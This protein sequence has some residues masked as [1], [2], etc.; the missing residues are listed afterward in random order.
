MSA[1]KIADKT[2]AP[3][4]PNL[5]HPNGLKRETFRTSRL[6]DFCS[7]RELVKQIGHAVNYWPLVILKELVDNA[8]D[9]AEEAN[10]APTIRI[11]VANGE[12]L[13]TDNGRRIHAETVADILDFTV[14]VSS[15]K[16]YA[17]PTWAAQGNALKTILAMGSALDSRQGETLIESHG[18]AHGI[19][20]KV[21]Q[22]RQEPKVEHLQGQSPVRTGTRITVRWP[23][24][25]S[26]RV[27]QAKPRFLQIASDYGWL[28]PHLSLALTWNGKR[29]VDFKASN[30]KWANWL[31]CEPTPPCWYDV[32][33]L[34]RLMGAYISRDQDRGRRPCKTNSETSRLPHISSTSLNALPSD[35]L[36]SFIERKLQRHGVKKIMPDR[37]TLDEASIQSHHPGPPSVSKPIRRHGGTR[38]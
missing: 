9:A 13:I 34:P 24:C 20:F 31:P 38:R 8:L 33:H 11:D 37:K 16:A 3:H 29:C 25:A 2:Q 10:I 15:R 27:D 12:I 14:R 17:S 5:A 26:S 21:D 23:V 30:P 28:N 7:V 19:T 22:V 18:I 6:L 4:G 32:S 35:Q 36:I 1:S